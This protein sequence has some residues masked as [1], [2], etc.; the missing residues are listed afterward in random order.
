MKKEIILDVIIVLLALLFFY[1]GL[2]KII[3]WEEFGSRLKTI[4]AFEHISNLIS[5]GVPAVELTVAIL[6][7]IPKT[8]SLALVSSLVLMIVFSVY[9]IIILTVMDHPPCNCG[10][11][12]EKMSWKQHL[13]FNI[14]YTI[15]ALTGVLLNNRSKM[16]QTRLSV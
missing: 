4:P 7:F 13:V 16:E 9:V 1:T 3:D 2:S 5:I 10:G 6:L 11:V 8:R 12:I 15:V 14:G